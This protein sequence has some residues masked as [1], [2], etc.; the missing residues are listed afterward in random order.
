MLYIIRSES[1]FRTVKSERLKYHV[2]LP[3]LVGGGDANRCSSRVL[4]VLAA[5]LHVQHSLRPFRF[6]AFRLE[7][8]RVGRSCVCA[9]PDRLNVVHRQLNTMSSMW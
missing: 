7:G 4:R 8:L 2:Q 5:Y 6:Y 1:V 9:K 3:I